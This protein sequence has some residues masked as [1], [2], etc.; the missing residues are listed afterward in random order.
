MRVKYSFLLLLSITVFSSASL[1]QNDPEAAKQA[2]A[3]A[4]A[5]F[6]KMAA[7]KGIAEAFYFFADDDATIKRQNDSLITGKEAIKNYYSAPFFKEASVTWSPDFVYASQSGDLGY[8]YGK[9]V[10]KGK[11]KDGKPL[12]S[13]GIFHTVWKKNSKGEWKYMWD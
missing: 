4:E 12:E 13:T 6:A 7:E 8:T 3:H 1:A 10:W 5:E 11:D 9:Y 2:I